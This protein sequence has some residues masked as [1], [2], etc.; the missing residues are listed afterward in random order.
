[1]LFAETWMDLEIIIPSEVS[2][3]DKY[4]KSLICRTKMTQMNLSTKQKQ[5]Q[6]YREQI[7]GCQGGGV[8]GGMD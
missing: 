4:M 3:K 1:M 6:R 2:Q 7:C 8:G 5:I